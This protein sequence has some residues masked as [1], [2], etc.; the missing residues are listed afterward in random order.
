MKKA[1]LKATIQS[2]LSYKPVGK[3]QGVLDEAAALSAKLEATQA[4]EASALALLLKAEA[5]VASAKRTYGAATAEALARNP[6]GHL[7]PQ[8]PEQEKL[9]QAKLDLEQAEATVLGCRRAAAALDREALVL[10]EKLRAEAEYYRETQAREF[11]R[12]HAEVIAAY[13][14]FLL[15]GQAMADA[16]G[17]KLS[18]TASNGKEPHPLAIALL[19]LPTHEPWN[20]DAE[21]TELHRVHRDPNRWLA[22]VERLS[23]E[24]E[25]RAKRPELFPPDDVPVTRQRYIVRQTLRFD[26]KD[27]KPGTRISAFTIPGGAWGVLKK[28]EL[29]RHITPVEIE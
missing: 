8:V 22:I 17:V 11:L 26:G 15:H 7:P 21:A 29:V 12:E 23:K 18:L 1:E 16:L 14:K 24:A 19:E 9:E 5:A 20:H 13:R 2:K 6:N 25:F 3:T 27:M 28:L 10:R 4:A